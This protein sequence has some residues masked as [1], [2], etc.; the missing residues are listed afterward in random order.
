MPT[1]VGYPLSS[2]SVISGSPS[3]YIGT[4]FRVNPDFDAATDAYTFDFTD[5]DAN[6]SGDFNVNETGDDN[7]QSVVIT[8]SAGGTVASGQVYLEDRSTFTDQFGNTVN[9]FRVE[10]GGVHHGWIADGELTPGVTYEV[11]SFSNV[12]NSDEPLYTDMVSATHDPDAANDMTGGAL[13][14]DIHGGADA[15]TITAGAGNDS[16]DGGSG[17][18]SL[19]G[20][21]GADTITGGDGDDTISGGDGSDH[22]SGGDGADVMSGGDG[23]DSLYGGAGSDTLSGG[24]GADYFDGGDGLDYLDYSDSDQ[25]VTVDLDALTGSGGDAEGD[26]F[27]GMDGLFGSDHDD[28]LLGYDGEGGS[29]ASYYTN[30]FHGGDGDDYIDG[31]GGSDTLYGDGGDDTI[32][33]GAG[34]DDIE[35]GDDDDDLSGGAGNDNI[36]GEL[37]DDTLSGGSGTDTLDGGAGRD[38]FDITGDDDTTDVIGGETGTDVDTIA[39]DDGTTSSGVTVTFSG[40]EIG[41]Y[42]FDG[43]SAGGDFSEIEAIIGTDYADLIDASASSTDQVLVGGTGDGGDVVIGGSGDDVIYG[44]EVASDPI[45]ITSGNYSVT[46]NG[47]TVTA[48]NVSGGAMTAPDVANIGTYYGGFGANGTISDSDSAVSAQTGFDKAS[49]LSENVTITFDDDVQ[50]L[51]F[52]FEHL[53]TSSFGEVGHWAVYDDGVLV[54][55]GD[56]SEDGAGSGA[57]TIDLS[58]IGPIDQI[59]FTAILQTDGTDGSDYMLTD[60]TFTSV[61]EATGGGDD[62]LS[63]GAG[64]DTIYGQG[65]EDRITGGAGD[66][67]LSGGAGNDTFVLAD[68]S[69]NDVI[70]DFDNNDDNADGRYNDQLD[71]SGLTNGSG[72]PVRARDVVV[73]DDGNGNAVLTFP[74]GE[75]I[76]L[77]GR[78]PSEIT[79]AGQMYAAGIPCFTA[80]TMIRTPRGEMR[81]ETLRPGDFVTTADNG[82]QPIVWIGSRRVSAAEMRMNPKLRPVKVRAGTLGAV[83]DTLFSQQHGV[84]VRLNDCDQSF[85]ARARMLAQQGPGSVRIAN[86]MRHV[87]FVHMLFATH[88][89]VFGNGVASESFLPGPVGFSA[90]A[91]AARQEILTLFPELSVDGP[92]G[93]YGAPA[94]TFVSGRKIREIGLRRFDERRLC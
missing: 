74:N 51:S 80:G 73:S 68:G 17:N 21:A 85:F 54:S 30:I 92:P 86:G 87:T 22:L 40:D 5:D 6:I 60:V 13:A 41:S 34:N 70:T 4:Q 26:T 59:V 16:I 69:G 9:I 66:D 90:L 72:D 56:F 44:D 76:V 89:V 11:A 81:I 25:G 46:S 93:W 65:G 23:D 10:I 31:R 19:S 75:S 42:A 8:N 28:V 29:G 63:G 88:Q 58:G 32:I 12:T 20:E 33:G 84:L 36:F 45:S 94:R 67:V 7:N 39:F 37:G 35:G 64:S 47:Y 57:G 3:L 49:G 50:D 82:P 83:R 79:T 18:D 55:E 52:S 53:Y 48:Q 15:D 77:R 61:P 1:I 2:L 27:Y 62:I 78:A 43:S 24:A 38:R 14:D 91:H 71:V